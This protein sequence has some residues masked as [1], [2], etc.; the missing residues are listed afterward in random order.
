MP[1]HTANLIQ[2]S[3]GRPSIRNIEITAPPGPTIQI[4]GAPVKM[5]ATPGGVHR[6]AP[7]L[8]EDTLQRLREVGLSEAEIQ[9]LLDKRA[10]YAAK[11]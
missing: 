8:G 1:S 7:H 6:R 9:D 4:A 11:I 2:V 3:A 5:T 10:A